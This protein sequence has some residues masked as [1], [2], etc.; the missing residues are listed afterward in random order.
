MASTIGDGPV[1][2]DVRDVKM[3]SVACER[4]SQ[5]QRV[6]RWGDAPAEA[7]TIALIASA[8]SPLFRWACGVTAER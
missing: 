7:D 4:R 2:S 3:H 5:R 8:G 1:S 6:Y